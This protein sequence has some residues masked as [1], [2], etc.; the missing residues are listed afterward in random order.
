[1]AETA[2]RQKRYY[3]RGTTKHAGSKTEAELAELRERYKA[4]LSEEFIEH[5]AGQLADA[6]IAEGKC[7]EVL[8][9]S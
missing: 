5:I 4:P 8:G 3:P 2:G 7:A 1:M 6:I 9:E